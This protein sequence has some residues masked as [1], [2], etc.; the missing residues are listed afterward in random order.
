MHRLNMTTGLITLTL[1][2]T[3]LLPGLLSCQQEAVGGPD[4]VPG[5]VAADSI[6]WLDIPERQND[7]L[8][9]SAFAARVEGGSRRGREKE[10]V[11]QV[12]AGNMPSCSRMLRRIDIKAEIADSKH[13]ISFWALNDYL[14]IG[15]DDDHLYIPLTPGCAQQ[16]ADSLGCL[17]PTR[18]IVD[19]IYAR[20]GLKLRPQ[21]IP[22]S[23]QMTNL[24]VFVQHND[25]VMLQLHELEVEQGGANPNAK[26][27]VAGHKKDII[28]SKRIYS[29][30]RDYDRVVIYGWHRG[31]NDPIQPVYSGHSAD[32]ADYSHGVRLIADSVTVNGTKMG[33][34]DLLADPGLA[35][36]LSDEG[37][38]HRAFY[39]TE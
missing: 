6:R 20:A 27:L 28:I 10:V 11:R 12:L 21:P 5:E 22:P 31:L 36:L 13:S 15:S 14:A 26:A 23:P 35:P 33:L 19:T 2:L 30:D 18:T 17:L 9:G 4:K 25:S 29:N 8:G 1:I 3:G 32:Y 24:P 39:P 38:I 16:I 7:A 37:V 34:N